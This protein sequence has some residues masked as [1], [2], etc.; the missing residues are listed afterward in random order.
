MEENFRPRPLTS[1]DS[2][3]FEEMC[4]HACLCA[5]VCVCEGALTLTNKPDVTAICCT[6]QTQVTSAGNF[7][8]TASDV[9][10]LCVCACAHSAGPVSTSRSALTSSLGSKFFSLDP[11]W[12]FFCDGKT[13]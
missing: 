10:C 5:F 2:Q 8:T 6:K 12:Y 9:R 13:N 4:S 11:R 7:L 1:E 3:V